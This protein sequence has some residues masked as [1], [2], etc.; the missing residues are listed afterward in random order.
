MCKIVFKSYAD[1]AILGKRLELMWALWG[2][3]G[4]RDGRYVSYIFIYA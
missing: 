1:T 4:L 3:M 2:G